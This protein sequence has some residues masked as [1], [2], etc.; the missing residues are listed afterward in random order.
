MQYK[1]HT[2]GNVHTILTTQYL[3]SS[4]NNKSLDVSDPLQPP[5]IA[6]PF[7]PT[8]V[9]VKL[10]QGGGACPAIVTELHLSMKQNT[11]IKIVYKN[12]MN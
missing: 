1:P 7:S 11:D 4:T 3:P 5:N 2:V 8:L 12:S 9:S 6:A 10:E